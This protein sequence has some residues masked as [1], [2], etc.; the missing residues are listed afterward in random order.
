MFG[1]SADSPVDSF[2]VGDLGAWNQTRSHKNCLPCTKWRK[3]YEAYSDPISP[4]GRFVKNFLD[5][6]QIV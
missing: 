6:W 5:E 4:Y 3:S 2:S 1:Q